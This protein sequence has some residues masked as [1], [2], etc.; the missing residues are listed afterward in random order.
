M[1]ATA[2][3]PIRKQS[4]PIGV[5]ELD[6]F[7]AMV[8][9]RQPDV[10]LITEEGT[11]QVTAQ[12]A[13][14]FEAALYSRNWAFIP[15]EHQARLAQVRLLCVGTGLGSMVVQLAA[16][17]GFQRYVLCDG[18]TVTVDNLNRQAF[19]REQIN[20]NK[21]SATAATIR[22]LLP[23]AEIDVIPRFVGAADFPELVA[24]V[25]FV[26]NTIDLDSPAF[27][28]LNRTARAYG[29]TV[30]F[31]INLGWGGALLVF[32]PES[33]SLDEFLT[34]VSV[35]SAETYPDVMASWDALDERS[36]VLLPAFERDVSAA[37]TQLVEHVLARLPN[38]I[39]SYL[40]EA[41]PAFRE[42]TPETW[43]YD[44]QLGVAA[45]LTAAIT[46]R[47]LVHLVDGLPVRTAPDVI[48]CDPD[49]LIAPLVGQ[50]HP[51]AE[52]T[53]LAAGVDAS[54]YAPGDV[55]AVHG[56]LGAGGPVPLSSSD[57]FPVRDGYDVLRRRGT[58]LAIVTVEHGA[59][60][61]QEEAAISAYRLRQ[62]VMAGLYDE[63]IVERLARPCDPAMRALALDDL[64]IV[65]VSGNGRILCYLCIQS[66]LPPL[67]ESEEPGGQLNAGEHSYTR[68]GQLYP[69]LRDYDR[70][71]F[72]TETEYGTSLFG[73]HP[74]LGLI[75]VSGVR[76]LSRLV[77]N[78]AVEDSDLMSVAT[79]ETILAATR[80]LCDPLRHI[81]A[82]LGCSAPAARRLLYVLGI[83]LAFAPSAPILGPNLGGGALGEELLWSADAHVEGR[84]W[85]YVL[86]TADLRQEQAYFD[87]L[88]DVLGQSTAERALAELKRVRRGRPRVPSRY[89]MA[90]NPTYP[91]RWVTDPFYRTER[92]EGQE[93][94]E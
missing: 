55:A 31:P 1:D 80:V 40:R 82:I 67:V 23:H 19:L 69:L 86:A 43:P 5:R 57:L 12:E 89:A 9:G 21:A 46:V 59:L 13:H 76:E 17:T 61:T 50:D 49:A 10:P 88:D 14:R 45:H 29:K 2:G 44:P 22:S 87:Q 7:D 41:I 4:H 78:Q 25:D 28:A 34:T 74:A 15:P 35:S 58:G 84:F 79:A 18:D 16:R 83:P 56:S 85:P 32:T 75:P 77:H 63:Q 38:G 27:L 92:G 47:T 33:C 8:A 30:L 72:P 90:P 91:Y 68:T 81:E 42:R 94:Q 70:L 48:W 71:R 93:G 53:L 6:G 26:I 24:D 36:S 3:E 54:P 62:Y 52:S 60:S 11:T 73:N 65:A 66:T 51:R 39:P 37:T 64:H 20:E